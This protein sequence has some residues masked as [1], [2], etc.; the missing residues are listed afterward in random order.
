MSEVGYVS[1]RAFKNITKMTEKKKRYDIEADA[2]ERLNDRQI[3]N[4]SSILIEQ[5]MK[6]IRKENRGDNSP[7]KRDDK[8][9]NPS[10]KGSGS[11]TPKSF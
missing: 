4:P 6:K 11:F 8:T 9:F 7:T 10:G 3:K 5:E 1:E 2:I